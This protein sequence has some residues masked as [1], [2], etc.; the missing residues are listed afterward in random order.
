M[1]FL[2][3]LLHFPFSSC[4]GGDDFDFGNRYGDCLYS[5]LLLQEQNQQINDSKLPI[6]SS[7]STYVTFCQHNPSTGGLR[8]IGEYQQLRKDCALEEGRSVRNAILK[9]LRKY[10]TGPP[11]T[12]GLECN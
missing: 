6:Q 1:T 10:F 4:P 3:Y 12:E 8:K 5:L 11:E 7:V 9:L 2:E